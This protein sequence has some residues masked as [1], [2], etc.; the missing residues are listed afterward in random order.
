VMW[1][2]LVCLLT[3]CS[4][5]ESHPSRDNDDLDAS[6]AD[7]PNAD[8]DG[9]GVYNAYDN[10]PHASN[11]DQSDA[12]ADGVGDACEHGIPYDYDGDGQADHGV[13]N[14]ATGNWLI[15][16]SRDGDSTFNAGMGGQPVPQDYDGDRRYDAALYNAGTWLLRIGTTITMEQLGDASER[17]VPADYDGDGKADIATFLPS[18]CRWTVKRSFDGQVKSYTFPDPC[19]HQNGIRARPLLGDHDHD[20]MSDYNVFAGS[21]TTPDFFMHSSRGG[22]FYGIDW[23]LPED[24]ASMHDYN[25]DGHLDWIAVRIEADNTYTFFVLY[26]ASTLFASKQ[27]GASPAIPVTADYDGDG[28]ADLAVYNPSTQ[29]FEINAGGPASTKI[30]TLPLSTGTAGDVPI[31]TGPEFGQ[32]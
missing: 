9:D 2:A 7:P 11:T 23:G 3:G 21:T 25:G 15:R 13:Y 1:R 27:L 5:F 8:P 17:P 30:D 26:Y 28:M 22:Y 10:C 29:S 20:G 4:V 6:I 14:P 16:R 12:N 19:V 32:P 31:N 24:I 18:Q